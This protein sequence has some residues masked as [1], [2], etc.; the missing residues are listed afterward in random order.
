MGPR[1]RGDDDEGEVGAKIVDVCMSMTTKP[2]LTLAALL[3]AA[4]AIAAPY[5]VEATHQGYDR[6][7]DAVMAIGDGR[8]TILIAPGVYHDCTVQ[9]EGWIIYKAVQPGMSVFDSTVCE[10]KAV[11]VLRGRGAEVDG[12][13]F[14]RLHVDDGNGAG[15]RAERGFLTVRRSAFR[16]SEEGILGNDDDSADIRVEGST[17]S[18]L[19]RCDRGLSCAHS[20]YIGHYRSVTVL[21]SRF[22]R[23]RGGHYVKSRSPAIEVSD[24]SFDDVQGHTTNYMI[25]L[26]AGATGTIRRTVFVQGADKEN[27]SA[28]VAVAAE[29]PSNPSTG[30][31]VVD[32]VA[33][34]V[35]GITWPT[36]LVSDFSHSQMVV[37]HNILGPRITSYQGADSGQGGGLRGKA[38][39]YL[40]KVKAK[41]LG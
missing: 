30:L 22:E 10:G 17:F 8:G 36:A 18:G 38:R 7:V 24:C 2:L 9:T 20:I 31:Q 28:I 35:P 33:H 34:Q 27:H 40:S 4:P 41:L 3:L 19:G 1:F 21:R 11:L 12:I 23:G 15:I 39:H 32:N 25:D 6:L 37:E 26:P 16:D 29:G 14:R 5:T 13:V